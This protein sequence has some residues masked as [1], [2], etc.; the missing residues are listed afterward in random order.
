MTQPLHQAAILEPLTRVSRYLNWQL[1]PG[2]DPKRALERLRAL[3][4]EQSFVVGLGSS[5]LLALD[6]EIPG[7]REAPAMAGRGVSVP[8]TPAA[9]WLWLRGD[10]TGAL[11][12]TT[13]RFQKLLSPDF[14]LESSVDAFLHA[15]GRDLT[16]YVDGTE[17]P[18]GDKAV[19]AA[20]CS[21]CAQGLRG[22][23]FVAV[24]RWEHRLAEF[25]RRSPTQRDLTIGRSLSDDQEIEDAPAHAHVKRTAQES[26]SPE[27]FIVRR[28]MPWAQGSR[29]GLVFVAFGHSFDAFEALV[30]RM[31]GL[32][33]GIVDALFQFTR[34]LTGNYFW[35]PPVDPQGKLDLSAVL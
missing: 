26:F 13:H 4:P 24:Q 17:N 15:G 29:E 1:S 32:E 21:C 10:D 19:S 30:R 35:C 2:A 7:L 23:S 28:S 12:Q 20:L 5:L 22:S 18:R 9:L 6:A 11:I 25:A 34:P 3:E 27:A 8:S 16:G 31:L 33:D 14:E